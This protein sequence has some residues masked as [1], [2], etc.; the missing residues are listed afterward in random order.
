MANFFPTLSD[1]LTRFIEAQHMFFVGTAAADGTV[2]VSPK[3]MD[4]LKV[5]APNR[6]IWL[7]VTGSGNESAAHV[8]KNPRMTIMFCSF[9]AK[10]LILRLYGQARAVHQND[11]NWD[12][13]SAH[14]PA[15]AGTRQIF[16]LTLDQV[17]TS[18]GYAVP[19]FDYAGERDTLLNWAENKGEDGLKDYWLE[20]N[21]QSIDG[22]PTLI[23][24]KNLPGD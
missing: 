16:D 12:E 2:N 3:G 5:L 21:Q 14:L 11:D 7:N 17:Q 18:C 20:N 1:E 15:L 22:M 4:S 8:L 19:F 23:A 24:E 10:P 6:V 13:L 9:E